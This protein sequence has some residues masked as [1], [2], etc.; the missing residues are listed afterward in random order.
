MTLEPRSGGADCQDR[1]GRIVPRALAGPI[2]DPRRRSNSAAMRLAVRSRS[3]SA[4]QDSRSAISVAVRGRAARST[5]SGRSA[6]GK[7]CRRYTLAV[8]Q[9]LIG[10]ALMPVPRSSRFPGGSWRR[11]PRRCRR[12]DSRDPSPFARQRHQPSLGL[13]RDRRFPAGGADRR[14][15][16]SGLWPRRVDA[17]L[18]R[19]L[20]Q[21]D[22][23]TYRKKRRVFP[24]QQYPRPLDP[25]HL[26]GANRRY[27]GIPKAGLFAVVGSGSCSGGW[28]AW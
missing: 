25:A 17:A 12:G 23:P 1:P 18:D 7:P 20:M 14:A 5:G 10:G 24:I 16:P 22:R 27:Q 21:P 4:S 28:I 15:Q 9:Q 26:D 19:L 8:P 6:T 2:L 3:L 11:A 13:Q